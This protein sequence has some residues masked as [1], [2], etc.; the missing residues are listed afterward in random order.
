MI[1]QMRYRVNLIK[2][3]KTPNGRGGWDI[4]LQDLGF[5][6]AAILPLSKHAVA[7]FQQLDRQADTSIYIR[8]DPE[9]NT[10]CIVEHGSM[11]YTINAV[12]DPQHYSDF[13]ELVA[14]GEK[15][16]G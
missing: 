12:L 5:R 2:E 10:N 13:M 4:V 8:R 1:G 3:V 15:T 9:I 6:W 14:Q 7:Q 11:T 16:N